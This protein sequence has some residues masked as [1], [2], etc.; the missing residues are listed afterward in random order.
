MT[1]LHALDVFDRKLLE[2]MQ[3]NCQR[4]VAAIAESIGLSVPAC[5]RRIRRLRS[6]GVIEREIA[7][8]RP[9]TLGWSLSMIV[10]VMLEREGGRT[11]E[12]MTRKLRAEP[13]VAEAWHVTGDFDLALKIV[14][15]DMEGFDEFAQRLFSADERVR[16]FKTL[17]VMREMKSR[18]PVPVALDD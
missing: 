7:I 11:I 9:R 18:S 3:I 8:V 13:E 14:A 15:R 5:Y 1:K 12:E 17:V 6:E 16:S 2:I 4:P 10:L